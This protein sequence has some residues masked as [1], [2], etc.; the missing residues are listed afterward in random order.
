[1]GILKALGVATVVAGAIAVGVALAPEVYG[2]AAAQDLERARAVRILDGRGSEIGV[3]VRD[4]DEAEVRREKLPAAS[5][6]VV[7]EVRSDSPAARAGL[8]SGDVIVEFDGERVRSARHFSRVVQ[9]TPAGRTVKAAVI[10]RGERAEIQVTP[11]ASTAA[12][13]IDG[14]RIGRA[15]EEHLG[16]LGRDFPMDFDFD[17]RGM[18]F[19]RGR[20]G[21]TVEEITPQLADYFGVKDGVL[22]ASVEENSPAARAGLKAGDVITSIDNEPIRS[23]ADLV[24]ELRGT[25]AGKEIT[26][27]ASRDRKSLTLKATLEDRPARRPRST[28]PALM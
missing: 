25:D 27:G 23:R 19:P 6:A 9:E 8:K 14:E 17:I 3:S 10:R 4:V 16:R 18:P 13:W 21:V 7:E 24:R 11:D 2:R 1:M 5:G 26:I 28:R 12:M 15:V 20:L 22:V